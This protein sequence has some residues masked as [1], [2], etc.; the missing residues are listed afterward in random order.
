MKNTNAA[1]ATKAV[2]TKKDGTPYK[3]KHRRTAAEVM[4]SDNGLVLRKMIAEKL[5][6]ANRINELVQEF[7]ALALGKSV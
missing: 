5:I 7:S 6:P 1:E 4:A 2:R 3:T